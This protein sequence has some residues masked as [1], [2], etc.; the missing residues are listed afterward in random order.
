[1]PFPEIWYDNKLMYLA[2]ILA[3]LQDH[4]LRS[5][6]ILGAMAGEQESI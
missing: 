1:M 6:R 5:L 4:L 2:A 3:K